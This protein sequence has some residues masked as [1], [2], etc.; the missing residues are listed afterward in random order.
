MSDTHDTTIRI[1][2]VD[3]TAAGTR[4]AIRNVEQLSQAAQ[5]AIR[6]SDERMMARSAR[7]LGMTRDHYRNVHLPQVRAFQQAN[8]QVAMGG[9]MQ[10]A[11]ANRGTAAATRQTG[12]IAG[13]T[14][15][16]GPAAAGIGA[17]AASYMSLSK[18]V[19]IAVQ[20]FEQFAKFDDS[21][22][23]WQN[24]M[25]VNQAAMEKLG[26]S[27]QRV[28]RES[29]NALMD[30]QQAFQQFQ[31]KLG[32]SADDTIKHM[33]DIAKF[34]Y[35]MNTPIVTMGEVT[36]DAMR[37]LNIPMEQG[38]DV[39][40]A[41]SFGTN[42][43][44]LN[45]KE[46]APYLNKMTGQM[47]GWGYEGVD[48]L[49][50]SMAIIGKM[51]DVLGNSGEAAQVFTSLMDKL[52]GD[53]MASLMGWGKG[54]ELKKH[55]QASVD[56][57][58]EWVRLMSE[59]SPEQQMR[60]M[61]SLS[62]REAIATRAVAAGWYEIGDNVKRARGYQGGEKAAENRAEGVMHELDMLGTQL[63]DLMT[64]FGG[65]LADLGLTRALA[66]LNEQLDF[67][68]HLL[69][70]A[71][72]GW[73]ALLRGGAMPELYTK[74]EKERLRK[75]ENSIPFY[76]TARDFI[77][78]PGAVDAPDPTNIAPR[79]Q[80]QPRAPQ[81]LLH[82]Q[83]LEGDE[84]GGARFIRASDG[85]VG[86]ER[87]G[88]QAYFQ[89]AADDQS[90]FDRAKGIYN[91]IDTGKTTPGPRMLRGPAGM[92]IDAAR[93]MKNDSQREGHPLRSQLR[94][95]L[96]I[97]DLKEPAPWQR[98]R[99][100]G[101]GGENTLASRMGRYRDPDDAIEEGQQQ[102]GT[103]MDARY[104]KASYHPS[105]RVGS[106][107]GGGG[108][109]GGGGSQFSPAG[110]S[111]RPG[112]GQGTGYGPAGRQLPGTPGVGAARGRV[113]KGE[114]PRGMEQHI[115]ET[116]AK[117][118]I[119]PD[120]AVAVAKSEGLGTF[121]SSVPRT[122]KG[123]FNGREDSWGAFQMY[124]GGG[125]GN[126][127]Q[128][129]TGLDPRDPKN[130]KATIDFALKHASKHGWGAWYG[131]RNTGIGNRAGI[132]GGTAGVGPERGRV[133]SASIDPNQQTGPAAPGE[134]GGVTEAQGRVAA[135]RK[136]ALDPQLREALEYAAEASGVG[137][138]VTSGGQRM[139]GAPGRVGS[140][141]HNQGKA[142]DFDVIDPK[143]GKILALDDP[144]RVKFL[145]ESAAAGAGGTGTQYM[146][147][148]RKIH[149]GIT[150][151]AGVVGQGLGAYS[152]PAHEREAVARGLRRMMTPQQVAEARKRQIAAR[153]GKETPSTVVEATPEEKKVEREKA[154]EASP[155]LR[156]RPRTAPAE[157]PAPA[158]PTGPPAANQRDASRTG[159]ALDTAELYN[160]RRQREV[161]VRFKVDKTDYQFARRS[162][163]ADMNREMRNAGNNS[164]ADSDTMAA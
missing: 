14:R 142:A 38:R 116:A 131:A 158:A 119:D 63:S 7:N 103:S 94:D 22:R 54:G 120:T 51:K 9:A 114:D 35:G 155:L 157:A 47:A 46:I 134:G 79:V 84:R 33:G 97:E 1:N 74:E 37:N 75:P 156:A 110:P 139:E 4:S 124:M 42:K 31:D 148:P 138:R 36:A 144:R 140:L 3:N 121:Q 141:R 149:A 163:M 25:G 143:T 72:K 92:A 21:M 65:L 99:P 11:W 85:N 127:F 96:G 68:N 20:S 164:H 2:A 146:D 81:E 78:R 117:Y 82:R 105:G 109:G 6:R 132:P 93:A 53:Q 55:L 137:V 40:Q 86:F 87:D 57:V 161:N 10:V 133:Q 89:L 125:L 64:N 27:I 130:E 128:R 160:E 77:K 104:L 50:R 73:N 123:S 107:G 56:P 43:L 34:A 122:G 45:M 150:G 48:G 12:A 61:N 23:V 83:S 162:M 126:D 60:I 106:D 159:D 88:Q 24:Q 44:S 30:T 29:G 41:L 112:T 15:M 98:D 59:K 16:F 18:A 76:K 101:S 100:G 52:G 95:A 145:E 49:Q 26:T 28:S 135:V 80:E 102:Y 8:Q 58:G 111:A 136:G 113:G 19:D 91:A 32:A 66:A 13:L 153:K 147:D 115:R 17:M 151:A 62:N 108:G 39:M 69:V 129:A 71:R 90:Y 152:G 118:G 67:M 70:F 5:D 154:Y